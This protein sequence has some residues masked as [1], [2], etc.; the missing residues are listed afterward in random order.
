LKTQTLQ[1][2]LYNAVS[3]Y[4]N[5]P[6]L[7]YTGETPITYTEVGAKVA[8]ISALLSKEGIMKSD[9]VAILG[10][11]SPS[12]AL[13]FYATTSMGAIAVPLLT[14]FSGEEI[15]NILSHSEASV[16]LVSKK[17]RYKLALANIKIIDLDSLS[18]ISSEKTDNTNYSVYPEDIAA[19][20][21]TS[22]TTG[23][24]KGVMLTH[25]NITFTA[26]GGKIVQPIV[27]GD[28]FLS[29]LPL[30]H[31][32]ENTLGL[33]LPFLGGAC[34][35]YL[36]A[37][38]SPS[39]MMSAFKEVRPTI[40]LTVPMIIEKVFR[41]KILPVFQK[42]VLIKTFYKLRLVQILLHKVAGKK[43]MDTFGGELKFFGVGGA[44]I[45]PVVEK[46]LLD[47][48]FPIA[49]G[50]GLTETAPLLAGTSPRTAR[51]Q[52]TG[53]AIEGVEL[54]INNPDPVTGI[55]EIWAKGPNVMKGYYKEPELTADVITPDG[56]FK[57]GDLARLGRENHFYIKGRNK[58]MIL[59]SG[60]ENI[61]PEDIESLI[62]GFKYV[63]ES[64]VVE[65]NGKLVAMVHFNIEELE[66]KYQHLKDKFNDYVNEK[67]SE[68][69][70]ELHNYINQKVSRFARLHTV[71]ISPKPFEKTAT[72]KIKRYLY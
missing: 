69:Q 5:R 31:T 61:Y 46:F 26:E 40:L 28:R 65:Q 7:A 22:G 32:Y 44:K 60:G 72:H 3:R 24:S 71:I 52:S 11:N 13:G 43:L 20:I 18:E 19:L 54:K 23:R 45:D 42:N 33:I 4:G 57:T 49:I 6:A 15:E 56:W 14:G 34:I 38:L 58:N 2:V 68:L 27:P 64:L 9:K 21:Y 48:K 70:K 53:P 41:N 17:L 12:W 1:E 35:Y 63:M 51:W 62:N 36:K 47:A 25:K 30:S 8:S 67:Q 16:V 55:G 59:G 66:K 10:D 29:I 50:Y 39:V 37:A